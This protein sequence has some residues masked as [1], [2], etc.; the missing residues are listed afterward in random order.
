[1]VGVA[2]RLVPGF[3]VDSIWG[4]I[5][6]IVMSIVSSFFNWLKKD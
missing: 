5:F 2:D 6:S 1:M 3:Q 4:I